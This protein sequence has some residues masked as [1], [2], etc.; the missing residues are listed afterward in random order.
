MNDE[1]LKELILATASDCG[2]DFSAYDRKN[3]E[4][5]PLEMLEDAIA[6]NAVTKEEIAHAF[7]EG[8]EL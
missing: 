8:M 1:E 5:L 3:D 7:V 4:D 2:L 6:R